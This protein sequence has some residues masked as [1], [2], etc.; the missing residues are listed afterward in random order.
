[1]KNLCKL[2]C[3]IILTFVGISTNVKSQETSKMKSKLEIFDLTGNQRKIVYETSNHIEAPNWTPDGK[4]LVFNS[5]GL[6]YKIPID[7]GVPE[8]INTGI[9]NNCNNDH[10]ISADGKT[11]VVSHNTKEKG[12]IIYT[13][14]FSG[15]E[16]KQVTPN[17]PSYLH[18][19]SPDGK[20]LSYCAQRNNEY[21]VYTISINGGEETK[22]TNTVGLDDGPEYSSDGKY[23]YFNSVRTG[24]MQCYR[25][26][27]DGSDQEQLTFDDYHNWFPHPSPD[28]K[29]VVILTYEKGVVGHP[30]NKNVMLRLIP[31]NGGE[32]KVLVKLFGGQ[33]TI[34][35]HSWSPDS[36]QFAFVSFELDK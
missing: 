14:P 4:Y 35:V 22:L 1:M 20:T 10:V 28:L 33:G 31:F 13:I 18:G 30:A 11:L 15:G 24:L 9:A 17:G 6:I 5:N 34:N 21:D 2:N 23:I 32:P 7:G 16:A 29:R 19:I 25:M 12:S 3:I 26:K 8:K 36:K 27:P